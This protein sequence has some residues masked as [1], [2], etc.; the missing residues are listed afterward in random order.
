MNCITLIGMP[1]CGKSTVGVILAKTLGKNFVDADILIQ[2][3][4][5]KL[6]QDIIDDYGTYYFKEVEEKIL[7]GLKLENCVIATGGSAIYYD[8]AMSNLSKL[9]VVIYIKLSFET[10]KSRLNNIQTR[11]VILEKGQ[12]L[13]DLY[14]QR[15]PLYE[16]HADIII[17]GETK[18]PE[19][20][21][22]RI[23]EELN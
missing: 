22:A 14:D 17:D 3:H 6:L 9:G 4:E 10:I 8:A 2:E 13:K 1:A 16:K 15:T 7:T 5:G 11:G 23:L 18:N 19:E 20:V 12:T 21:I